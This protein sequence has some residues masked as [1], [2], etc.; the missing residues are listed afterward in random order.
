M[1]KAF[2]GLKASL[3]EVCIFLDF[4]GG[5]IKQESSEEEECMQIATPLKSDFK[6]KKT[7]LRRLLLASEDGRS[8]ERCEPTRRMGQGG[9]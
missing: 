8:D 3:L 6:M 9:F 7:A 5:R 4:V 1:G 2:I